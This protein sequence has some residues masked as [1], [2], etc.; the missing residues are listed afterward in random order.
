MVKNGIRGV[1]HSVSPQHLQ[2]YLNEYT[3]RYNHRD[4]DEPMFDSIL[5][6]VTLSTMVH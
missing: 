1:F 3:F 5:N 2:T 6:K 4:D